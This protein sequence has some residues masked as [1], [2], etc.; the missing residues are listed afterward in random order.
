MSIL[1]DLVANN[2][3]KPY[4]L[5]YDFT[6][7][8]IPW[9]NEVLNLI[10]QMVKLQDNIKE[11]GVEVK[12]DRWITPPSRCRK[13]L[14]VYTYDDPNCFYGFDIT[15]KKLKLKDSFTAGEKVSATFTDTE[16]DKVVC[17]P[18]SALDNYAGALM[19]VNSKTYI[20]ESS[21]VQEGQSTLI[22]NLLHE[23]ED[24]DIFSATS[25][26]LVAKDGY[27]IL[28]CVADYLPVTSESQEVPLSDRYE[29]AIATGLRVKIQEDLEDMSQINLWM[30]KMKWD[31]GLLKLDSGLLKKLDKLTGEE[32]QENAQA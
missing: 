16:N 18:S 27:L 32:N 12:A 3:P 23:R 2:I 14:L 13:P 9:V 6:E 24:A 8:W 7:H 11:C 5:R 10:P 17:V 22:L 21:E 31:L 29:K 15:D 1:K 25:G 20:V 28:K 4:R 26:Y 30:A 19:V